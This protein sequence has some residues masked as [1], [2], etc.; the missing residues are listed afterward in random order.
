[1]NKDALLEKY[2]Q[3]KL[4]ASEKITFNLLLEED[5]SFAKKAAFHKDLKVAIQEQDQENFK[6]LIATIESE[7]K[8]EPIKRKLVFPKKWFI[9]ASIALLL[10]LTFMLTNRNTFKPEALFAANF[11][12]YKNVIY[13]INRSLQNPNKTK[14]AIAFTAYE[15]GEYKKASE[16]FSEL[17]KETGESFYLFYKANALL[18][19][20]EGKKAI[21][22]LK[23][24]LKTKDTLAEKS[25][26]YLALAYL[27]EKDN[28]NTKR[29]LQEIIDKKSY[30]NKKAKELL[31][32][33][34]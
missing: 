26:W 18:K 8:A 1:M 25:N 27:K 33:L 7:Y 28:K 20:G 5:T 30:N 12:P 17:Y 6:E 4:T 3:N 19:L 9:A 24:H 13:P 14:K 32:K 15:N 23:K 22:T 11:T 34:P 29:I 16:L 21:I 10:G 2:I 31:K